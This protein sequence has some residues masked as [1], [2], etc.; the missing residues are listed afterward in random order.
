MSNKK[1]S[2]ALTMTILI[3]T[4]IVAYL[5]R[6]AASF[7]SPNLLEQFGA[8]KIQWASL[9]A[10]TSAAYGVGKFVM[11]N[12]ADRFKKNAVML[13][14]F[15]VVCGIFTAAVGVSWTWT[16]FLLSFTAMCF[17]QGQAMPNSISIICKTFSLENRSIAYTS[18]SAS[19]KIGT[20]LS[21]AMASFFLA[22]NFIGGIFFLP[23]VL[24][25]VVG[26]AVLLWVKD[27]PAS[28]F[29]DVSAPAGR[30]DLNFKKN[31]Y[32][33]YEVIK[34]SA[35]AFFLYMAYVL[36]ADMGVLFFVG[37]GFERAEAVKIMIYFS[38]LAL[39]GGLI[40]SVVAKKFF[41]GKV[42]AVVRASAVIMGLCFFA[43]SLFS[44]GTS[45]FVIAGAMVFSGMVCDVIQIMPSAIS[46]LVVDK[47]YAASATGYVGLWQQ[48]GL[49]LGAY[50][51]A[52]M[53]TYLNP[54]Y[55]AYF[56]TVCCL[57]ASV[58]LGLV[59]KKKKKDED[60][61]EKKLE[62]ERTFRSY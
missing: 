45:I 46:T 30:L 44:P 57:I 18:W 32:L 56:A 55:C 53:L 19:H 28:K 10:L 36:M 58:I 48:S 40:C 62:K 59:N 2:K 4:Y 13:G 52:G 1:Q 33:N 29:K 14:G 41:G 6:R 15:S 49:I 54:N 43:M 51:T 50:L 11:P 38:S 24:S 9:V 12:I 21:G 3:L 39:V 26:A 25:V 37:K 60:E 61:F 22:K 17:F 5:C 23:A 8:S 16:L 47:E 42:I 35:A 7:V 20:L 34:I 27:S 31:V